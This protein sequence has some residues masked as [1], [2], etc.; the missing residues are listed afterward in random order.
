M[1]PYLEHPL[2]WPDV[3]NRLIAAIADDL[4]AK[5]RPRYYAALEER[6]YLQDPNGL[7]LVGRPD[8]AL[9]RASDVLPAT[10]PLHQGS[11]VLTVDVPMPD[12]V[13]ETYLEVRTSSGE[14][15]TVVELLSHSNKRPGEGRRLYE[16]KR[17]RILGSRTHLVE[18]DLL[19][20]GQP[21]PVLGSAA[22][23]DYRILISRGDR[24]PRAELY[25][26]GLREPIPDFD[27][28]LGVGEMEPSLR[29]ND[30]FQALYQRASYDLRVD[31]SQPPEPPLEPSD[32]AWFHDL[33]A[34][35]YGY[36]P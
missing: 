29:L 7:L 35:G 15:V 26:F 9:V 30:V 11:R 36:Q 6:T 33:L 27:I 10:V 20:A 5:L 25:L 24:R 3:H 28:P 1:D 19:R 4:G 14:V 23:A 18:I 16:L 8:L 2:L 13:R 22:P 12:E 21:M 17:A 32:A 34:P 31:Y